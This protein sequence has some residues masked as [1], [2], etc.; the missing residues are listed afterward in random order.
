MAAT[1]SND[2]KRKLISASML[3]DPATAA[4][5]YVLT[6]Q[7]EQSNKI[8]QIWKQFRRNLENDITE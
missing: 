2:T 1:N 8:N 4:R 5:Y 6:D 7:K 3:H